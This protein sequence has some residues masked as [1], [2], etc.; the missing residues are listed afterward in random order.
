MPETPNGVLRLF[1][2]F[3]LMNGDSFT[4]LSQTL[5]VLFVLVKTPS[6]INFRPMVAKSSLGVLL[7]PAELSGK[8]FP[9][10]GVDGTE[11]PFS[12][13]L[14]GRWRDSVTVC[15]GYA[16][17]YDRLVFIKSSDGAF[18][19]S[20][21]FSIDAT[22]SVAGLDHHRSKS[23]EIVASA[24]E[25]TRSKRNR[26]ADFVMLRLPRSVFHITAKLRDDTLKITHTKTPV[27]KD[28][29]N[30]ETPGLGPII[31]FDSA[32]GLRCFPVMRSEVAIFPNPIK[33]GIV[34]WNSSFKATRANLFSHW[35]DSITSTT[36]LTQTGA[37]IQRVPNGRYFYFS[38]V[39]D[40]MSC[41]I[42]S[43]T[44]V[45]TLTEGYY[46]HCLLESDGPGTRHG[47]Q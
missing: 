37:S 22:D 25:Q 43:E 15:V 24:Y 11:T 38:A 20:L 26:A 16:V 47:F 40:S 5:G 34:S 27:R 45:N 19:A 35:G 1:E 8:E 14:P 7:S 13:S 10:A 18:F 30:V 23:K 4:N 2:P 17:N 33:F 12:I 29:N 41:F 21:T 31:F 32:S 36:A 46:F 28:F 44:T 42:P 9:K 39:P 6:L 3:I